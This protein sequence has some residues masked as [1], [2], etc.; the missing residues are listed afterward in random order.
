METNIVAES[1]QLTTAQREV[2]K[3]ELLKFFQ[4][5]D[6]ATIDQFK[7]FSGAVDA[8]W[9][10]LLHEPAEYEKFLSEGSI[11]TAMGHAPGDGYGIIQWVGAYHEKF[12]QL[13]P[14]WFT[15][16]DGTVDEASYQAYLSTNVVVTA[17]DCGPI[18][19]KMA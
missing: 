3:A 9:H 2:G 17:W 10:D 12:G 14:I 7:M 19:P 18:L 5:V 13:D 1:A 11:D 16:A 4:L 6:P 15:A 8:V